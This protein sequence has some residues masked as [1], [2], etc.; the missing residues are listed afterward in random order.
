MKQMQRSTFLQLLVALAT[1]VCVAWAQF[2]HEGVVSIGSKKEFATT[3]KGDKPTFVKFYAPWC[4][5]WCVHAKQTRTKREKDRRG[6]DVQSE[7]D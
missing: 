1:L 5:H 3:V 6:V 4:G 2:D 7:R